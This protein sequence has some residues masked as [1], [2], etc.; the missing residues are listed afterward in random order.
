MYEA[1]SVYIH[2]S[3]SISWNGF[4]DELMNYLVLLNYLV[5][6]DEKRKL[7][8]RDYYRTNPN[9]NPNR[10]PSSGFIQRLSPIDW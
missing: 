10:N 8:N 9:R 1:S 6:P 2:G 7:N 5:L 3:I 4:C